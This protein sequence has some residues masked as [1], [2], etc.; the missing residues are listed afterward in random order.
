ML[1]KQHQEDI[2]TF[3]QNRS[4]AQY[5]GTVGGY[6]CGT[7]VSQCSQKSSYARVYGPTQQNTTTFDDSVQ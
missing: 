4:G 2:C 3:H 1:H 7:Y 5:I 6:G